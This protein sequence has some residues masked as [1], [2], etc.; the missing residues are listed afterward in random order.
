MKSRY[1]IINNNQ[2]KITVDLNHNI[3]N[4]IPVLEEL[5]NSDK[6]Y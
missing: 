1:T 6:S 4:T 3:D 5:Q 2:I